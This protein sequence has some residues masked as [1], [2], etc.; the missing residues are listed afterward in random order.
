M[1][2]VLIVWVNQV[3]VVLLL[4]LG[5]GFAKVIDAVSSVIEVERFRDAAQGI[6]MT[7]LRA[8]VGDLT[9]NDVLAKRDQINQVLR[10]KMDEVTARW[11]VKVTM[12]EIREIQPPRD[13]Q[14]AMTRQMSAERTRRAVVTEA[15]GKREA[16]I[17]VAE[18]EKQAA[19]LKAE[20]GGRRKS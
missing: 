12:V 14:D 1:K 10:I 4:S 11:G 9:L 20:G 7:T 18:G 17:M 15:N 13:V 2:P 6:A 8:V 3:V 5:L 19:I 16:A